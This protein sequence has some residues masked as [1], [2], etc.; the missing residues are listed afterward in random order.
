MKR[1]C[2][3]YLQISALY[4]LESNKYGQVRYL[5]SRTDDSRLLYSTS[6]FLV[7]SEGEGS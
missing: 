3:A 2:R 4:G 5:S 7:E 1:H 6:R